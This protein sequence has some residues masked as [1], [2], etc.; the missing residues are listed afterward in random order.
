MVDE[1]YRYGSKKYIRKYIIILE[2]FLPK[3]AKKN[4]IKIIVMASDIL[5]YFYYLYVIEHLYINRQY[6]GLRFISNLFF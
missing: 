6:T 5:P 3:G 4:R 1:Y 2:L